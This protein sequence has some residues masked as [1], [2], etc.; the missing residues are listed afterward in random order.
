MEI[1]TVVQVAQMLGVEP[2][3]VYYLLKQGKIKS[4][5]VPSPIPGGRPQHNITSTDEEIRQAH[6]ETQSRKYVRKDAG[7]YKGAGTKDS[8]V[9]IKSLAR[10]LGISPGAARQRI[11]AHD[12]KSKCIMVGSELAVPKRFV[13]R[14]KEV[15]G[16]S[17]LTPRAPREASP[18]AAIGNGLNTRMERIETAIQELSAK[19]D[20]LIKAWS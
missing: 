16:K 15:R 17:I 13:N 19:M 7:E 18:V 14:L 10:E 6:D 4:D 2:K 3:R 12:L 11:Y 8:Y 1:K 9:S 5:M 20:T